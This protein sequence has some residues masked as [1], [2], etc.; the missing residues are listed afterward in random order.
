MNQKKF[1]EAVRG[2]ATA[3]GGRGAKERRKKGGAEALPEVS[4]VQVE[5]VEIS[6][7]TIPPSYI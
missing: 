5:E 6:V 3:G 2:E 1:K 4:R 7:F